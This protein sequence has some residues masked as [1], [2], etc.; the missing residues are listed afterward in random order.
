MMTLSRSNHQSCSVRKGVLRNFTKFTGKHMY[1]S[2]F[3]NK[4][5]GLFHRTPL[6]DASYYQSELS[7]HSK[8]VSLLCSRKILVCHYHTENRANINYVWVRS[9]PQRTSNKKMDF[10]TP[11]LPFR[12]ILSEFK[13]PLPLP[14]TSDVSCCL[15]LHFLLL[16]LAQND[17]QM[18]FVK[19]TL[20]C[21]TRVILH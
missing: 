19:R 9:H 3:F 12:P 7:L 6:A 16:D 13:K 14:R 10:Q 4:A 20:F 11:P 18:L 1:Q 17:K 21:H 2:L 15:M 5:A 8:L